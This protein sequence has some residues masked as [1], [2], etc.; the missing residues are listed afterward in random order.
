MQMLLSALGSVD[1]GH[2]VQD[3]MLYSKLTFLGVFTVYTAGFFVENFWSFPYL[4][5]GF[6]DFQSKNN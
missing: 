4:P 6:A 1:G 5:I 2:A 3:Y